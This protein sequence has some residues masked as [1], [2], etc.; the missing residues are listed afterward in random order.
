MSASLRVMAGLHLG[1]AVEVALVV[2]LVAAAL[3]LAVVVLALQFG[4]PLFLARELFA[5]DAPRI[6]VALAL[7]AGSTRSPPGRA[8]DAAGGGAGLRGGLCT[9]VIGAPSIVRQPAR[10]PVRVSGASV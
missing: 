10:G 7:H 1:H 8:A 9:M 6:A 4:Q 5:E 3:G 2:A